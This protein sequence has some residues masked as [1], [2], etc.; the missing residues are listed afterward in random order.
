[1]AQLLT[2]VARPAWHDANARRACRRVN[3]S[4]VPLL[5]SPQPTSEAAAKPEMQVVVDFAVLRLDVEL[6]AAVSQENISAV[7][8]P[9]HEAQHDV[10]DVV[11]HAE[12]SD[13]RR[14]E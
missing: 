10:R 3:A 7:P 4:R 12:S 9:R 8:Q 2:C 14:I 1:M 5:G 13:V 6:Q 11:G